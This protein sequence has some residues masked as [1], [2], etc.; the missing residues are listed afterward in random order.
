MTFGMDGIAIQ[1]ES[2]DAATFATCVE[3]V[4]AKTDLPLIL[5]A[6]DP[7]NMTAALD[8]VG[9]AKPA[10][11]A[12]TKDNI[13]QMVE[14]AKKFSCALVVRSSD[15]LGELAELTEKA[16]GTGLEDLI[17]DPGVR[18]FGDTLV[19][20]TQIRRLALK[21]GFRALGYPII[22]FPS[23][24]ASSVEE[25]TVL[26]GQHIA[27]YSSIIVMDHFS[28]A[29]VYPLLTLRLNLYTDPQKPIQMEPGIYAIGEP[30]ETSPLCVTTNFSLT[31]FSIAGELESSGWP[32]WLGVCDTEGLSVLTAWSA[33][34]LDAE[35]IAKT[36]KEHNAA[37][38]VSHRNLILPGKVAV[39]RG[40]LEDELPDWT[41]MVGPPEAMDVGGYLKANWKG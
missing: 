18:G 16:S 5:M 35:K 27:K 17:L 32:S 7:A 4:R 9:D 14:L 6:T 34:K 2:G 3:S 26:A 36:V 37:E 28:P 38:K 21:K 22:S 40:E 39:L 33:G 11:Y 30:K 23:E 24:A 10:I 1:N 25:E 15:G 31:Y 13:D 29:V 8:K 41:I 19:T 20:F 12:A